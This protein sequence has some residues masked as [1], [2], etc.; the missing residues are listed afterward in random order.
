MPPKPKHPSVSEDISNAEI[1][2]I[3]IRNHQELTTKIDL[4]AQHVTC[5]EKEQSVQAASL[6]FLHAE[7]NELKEK[8]TGMD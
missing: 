8:L 3:I 1:K 7:M 4:L 5:L 6:D 2:E